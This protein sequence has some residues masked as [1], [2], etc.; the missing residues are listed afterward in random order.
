M[1]SGIYQLVFSNKAVY[2]GQAQDIS[3]RWGQHVDKFKKGRASQK[4]QAAYNT[5]GMPDFLLIISCHKDYLDIMESYYI[6]INAKYD[7]CLNTSIPKLDPTI[8]YD[9]LFEHDLF[10]IPFIDMADKAIKLT[11]EVTTLEEEL[12]VL[13]T[14]HNERLMQLRV[15]E[16]VAQGRDQNL[17]YKRLY[18][19][20]E[21][22]YKETQVQLATY[23]N[24]NLLQ[25]IFNYD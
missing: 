5:C 18:P 20:I 11:R 22:A 10:N 12:S 8:N 1:T 16:E 25:R 15:K 13:K 9:V 3:A 17:E 21:Q 7:N 2:I 14:V 23:Q 24:R 19:S 4:M 6:N